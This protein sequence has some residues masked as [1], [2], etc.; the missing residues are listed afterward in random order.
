M[1]SRRNA[2][3]GAAG[4]LTACGAKLHRFPFDYGQS[5]QGGFSVT[6]YSVGCTLVR[7]GSRSF[8]TDPFWSHRPLSEVAAWPIRHDIEEIDKHRAQLSDVVAILVGHGHYDHCL[9][10]DQITGDI[11]PDAAVYGSETLKRIFAKSAIDKPI[12][13]VNN[14]TATPEKKGT[15]LYSEDRR[16]RVLP[17]LSGHPNQWLCFHLFK[18][19][20]KADLKHPPRFAW[21]YQEGISLAFLVDFLDGE[22]IEKRVYVQ[23]S[24]TGWPAGF[25]PKSVLDEAKVDLAILSMDCA[26]IKRKGIKP[27]II[28]FINPKTVLFC[29]WEDFFLPKSEIPREI[30]KVDLPD[31]K[32][33]FKSTSEN[34]YLF[35]AWNSS[36][37]L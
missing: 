21:D 12:V 5:I 20:L 35:P 13:P 31:L 10:L 29:H 37:Q 2:L 27:A 16:L 17:I 36:F 11:R 8:L 32:Q 25:F 24:S 7:F 22:T 4:L 18:E 19:K 15:W 3:L 34:T 6:Y 9:D 33:F 1:Y 28:D 23:T 30:V 14:L 26:N